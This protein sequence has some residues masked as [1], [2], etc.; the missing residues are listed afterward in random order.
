MLNIFS[1][2]V[3]LVALV[4]AIIGL[5]PLLG[6]ANWIVLP[7]AAIGALLGL[8]SR[9]SSGMYFCLIVFVIAIVRLYLGGGII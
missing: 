4:G 2:L 6:W 5:V 9:S 7:I 3:G 8:I 1:I